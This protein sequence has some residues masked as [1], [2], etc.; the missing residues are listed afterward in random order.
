MAYPSATGTDIGTLLRMIREQRTETPTQQP[1]AAQVASPI[2]GLVQEPLK[3]DEAV[4]TEHVASIKPEAGGTGIGTAP[5]ETPTPS[6]VGTPTPPAGRVVAPLQPAPRTPAPASPPS[7][8]AQ[9]TPSASAPVPTPVPTPAPPSIGT[10][11]RTTP[12]TPGPVGTGAYQVGPTRPSGG[13]IMVPNTV[14]TEAPKPNDYLLPFQEF[15]RRWVPQFGQS[16]F[17]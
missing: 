15:L 16:W 7:A 14:P 1:P 17:A 10:S 9:S 13:Q 12:T 6:P 3:A 4:G 8:P 11:I 2:R 5:T